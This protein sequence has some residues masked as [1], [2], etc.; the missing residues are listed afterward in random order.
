MERQRFC[1][2]LKLS[3]L[4]LTNFQSPL[5]LY[6]GLYAFVRLPDAT[7]LNFVVEEAPFC[8]IF[9]RDEVATLLLASFSVVGPCPA[10]FRIENKV[11]VTFETYFMFYGQKIFKSDL[12]IILKFVEMSLYQ[13]L[14]PYSGSCTPFRAPKFRFAGGVSAVARLYIQFWWVTGQKY[15]KLTC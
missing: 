11:T 2:F 12:K 8:F 5:K 1:H 6:A 7:L 4:P 13:R 3:L 15:S 14:P 9:Y 10:W